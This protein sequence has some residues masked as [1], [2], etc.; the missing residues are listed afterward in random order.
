MAKPM[1]K[2]MLKQVKALVTNADGARVNHVGT[3]KL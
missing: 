1:M 3:S 2:W